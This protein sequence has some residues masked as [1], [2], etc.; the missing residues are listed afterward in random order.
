MD[1]NPVLI[2]TY[3]AHGIRTPISAEAQGLRAMTAIPV[4]INRMLQSEKK[5][6]LVS[7]LRSQAEVSFHR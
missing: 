1:A 7:R 5:S 3:S 4:A 6:T 2:A